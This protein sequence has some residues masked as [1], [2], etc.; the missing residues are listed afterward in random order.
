MGMALRAGLEPAT[1]SVGDNRSIQLSYGSHHLFVSP[2]PTH[3][4]R[5]AQWAARIASAP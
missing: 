2:D 1:C 4:D 5:A 3:D